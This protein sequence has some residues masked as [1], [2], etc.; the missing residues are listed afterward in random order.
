METSLEK[1]YCAES[2]E[3]SGWIVNIDYLRWRE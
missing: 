2:I 3:I 1:D